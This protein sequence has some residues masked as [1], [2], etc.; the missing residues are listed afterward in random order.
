MFPCRRMAT[1]R[2][3][4]PS[5][6]PVKT[7]AGPAAVTGPAPPFRGTPL[8]VG[9]NRA[10]IS[11]GGEKISRVGNAA[12]AAP[13]GRTGVEGLPGA[14][15]TGAAGEAGGCGGG[16]TA[17]AGTFGPDNSKVARSSATPNKP[18]TNHRFCLSSMPMAIFLPYPIVR[19]LIKAHLLRHDCVCLLAYRKYARSASLVVPCIWTF[20]S[21]LCKGNISRKDTFSSN[22]IGFPLKSP[23]ASRRKFIFPRLSDGRSSGP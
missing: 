3:A 15:A 4:D 7:G 5:I 13:L 17:G 1:R 20:L 14:V 10:A 21:S 11:A 22:G 6:T 18:M 8:P 23:A 12:L 16:S 19:L 9:G 2:P